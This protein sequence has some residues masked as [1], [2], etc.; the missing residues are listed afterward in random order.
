MHIQP[1]HPFT[2]PGAPAHTT[3]GRRRAGISPCPLSWRRLLARQQVA[4][5]AGDTVGSSHSLPGL[6][7]CLADPT[8]LRVQ[9]DSVTPRT[10][11]GQSSRR[12]EPEP[13][14]IAAAE[15]RLAGI[16]LCP[17]PPP[18]RQARVGLAGLGI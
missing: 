5:D 16:Y 15:P 13:R 1:A 9:G 6:Q 2:P 3:S 12:L 14:A 18:R 17:P 7:D 4:S 10:R 8:A 11:G